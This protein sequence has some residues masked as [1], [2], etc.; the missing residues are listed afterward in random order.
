MGTA[1]DIRFQVLGPWEVTGARG[2]VPI[3]AGRMRVLLASLMMSI[4]R[5]VPIKTLAERVWPEQRPSRVP[6]TL[7]T[8][9]ARLRRLLGQD[10]IQTTPGHYQLAVAPHRIDLWLFRD[11][12]RRASAAGEAHLELDL[13]RQAQALWR[14]Q[15]FTGVDSTWLDHEVSPLMMDEWFDATERRIDLEMRSNNPGDRIGELRELVTAYPARE[16][17]WVRLVAA[18]HRSGRR[19][20]ALDAYQQARDVLTAE[21]GREPGDALRRTHRRVLLDGG[22]AQPAR[23]TPV[24]HLPRE[25]TTFRDRAELA[26]LRRLTATI[27]RNERLTHIVAIE[28]PQGIGKTTLAVHWA[29]QVAAAY[30]DLRMHLDLRGYGPGEPMTASAALEALL[31]GAGVPTDLIPPGADERAAM[32]RGTLAGRRVLLLLDNARDA[33]QVRPLLP[34]ADSLVVVTSRTRLR[35]LSIRDGARQVTLGP[36]PPHEALAPVGGR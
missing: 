17:L 10:A 29:R 19:A 22:T 24:C 4:G 3:P 32:L 28:G 2:P 16:S 6:A 30:P 33:N 14:G 26:Q 31:R 21:L 12:L 11:L 36:L 9:V 1:A 18:L 8:Y 5:A 7:H 20:E 15:P 35:G 25:L 23:G 27:E 34:G 13:L